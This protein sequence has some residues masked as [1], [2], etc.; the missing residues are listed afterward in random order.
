V[1][2]P[3]ESR[4]CIPSTQYPGPGP[5]RKSR[6]GFRLHSAAGAGGRPPAVGGRVSPGA[7]GDWDSDGTP[8]GPGQLSLKLSVAVLTLSKPSVTNADAVLLSRD[9]C[10]AMIR[11][12]KCGLD[13]T[14]EQSDPKPAAL[15]IQIVAGI[16]TT[17]L[18]MSCSTCS[19][20][21]RRSRALKV[22][23]AQKRSHGSPLQ[24]KNL[25][26]RCSRR[27]DCTHKLAPSHARPATGPLT[28]RSPEESRPSGPSEGGDES[29][30]AYG[31]ASEGVA[32]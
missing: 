17:D 8:S 24:D 9:V 6:S 1:Q 26:A 20:L 11:T 4:R 15:F 5:G 16:E 22:S 29:P 12:H 14:H 21:S 31:I 2:A 19:H 27:S 32:I 3:V 7:V 28:A 10:T 23:F 13:R 30:G 18:N 25:S